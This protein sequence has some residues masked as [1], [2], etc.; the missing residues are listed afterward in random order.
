MLVQASSLDGISQKFMPATLRNRFIYLC[1]W[2][3]SADDVGK[4]CMYDPMRK[5][6]HWPYITK[7]VYVTVRKCHSCGNLAHMR[8]KNSSINCFSL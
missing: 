3:L 1:D 8:L 4:R 2:A 7:D 5:E 6:R